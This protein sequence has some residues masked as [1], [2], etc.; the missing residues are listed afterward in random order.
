MMSEKQFIALCI[1]CVLAA[2]GMTYL[3]VKVIKFAW[4]G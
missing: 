4:G 1:A 3:V 2:L